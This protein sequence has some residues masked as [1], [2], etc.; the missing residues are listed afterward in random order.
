M[1]SDT[2]WPIVKTKTVDGLTLHGLFVNSN[3]SNTTVIHCHGTGGSFYWNDFYPFI[4]TSL[5]QIGISFLTTN[6][7]GTGVYELEVGVVPSGVS[8][9]IF[10]DSIKD[11]DA[12]IEFA[13]KN[14]A[15]DIILEGHSFGIGKTTYY[16]AKGKY[17]NLVKAIIH[18][19]TNGVFKTQEH[20]LKAKGVS[21]E[22]YL[23]EAKGLID[24]SNPTVPLK[25]LTA[26]AGYY[27]V[28][29]QT[30]LNFFSVGSEMF[31]ST[32]MATKQDGGYRSL[33]NIPYLWILG[34]KTESEY[35]FIPFED[36]FQLVRKENPQVR[37]H[38]LDCNHGLNGKE[39]EVADIVTD[40]VS[41]L[42]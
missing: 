8:L 4:A 38:Q 7:R 9:E 41:H 10:E 33:I 15:K 28:S 31:K 12:W 18:L 32:Q 14:G 17:K 24:Q 5:Q 30:Y 13:L 20:Y 39:N 22:I 6:S 11:I 29:A 3:G 25:D 16:L 23:T 21:P 35:L 40:F 42:K 2:N 37:I 1:N 34:N 26:L 36:A 19:G 27:P